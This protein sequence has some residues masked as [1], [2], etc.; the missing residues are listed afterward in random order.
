MTGL[1]CWVVGVRGERRQASHD[2]STGDQRQHGSSAL[3]DAAWVSSSAS[4][5]AVRYRLR[6]VGKVMEGSRPSR[7]QR[8]TVS[9]CTFARLATSVAVNSSS[10]LGMTTDNGQRAA[11]CQYQLAVCVTLP[12]WAW[13]MLLFV[14][15]VAGMTNATELN[16]RVPVD[17]F[18]IRL[19]IVRAEMGWNY[20]QAQLATG[21]NSETWRL[22]EKGQ[23][24]CADLET[25]SR[26]I[27]EA[28]GLSYRWLMIGGELASGGSSRPTGLKTR[29]PDVSSGYRTR[30]ALR[31][32]IIP[33]W[34]LPVRKAS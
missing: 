34:G 21:I 22:W 33:S 13:R 6:P 23:R 26:K 1:R 31:P 11:C 10:L 9:G 16:A 28:T 25:A 18:G 14:R 29:R 2:H 3:H 15:I 5:S 27:S 20:D 12:N 32:G 7:V 19:A 24:K 4:T 8:R 30:R 17:R